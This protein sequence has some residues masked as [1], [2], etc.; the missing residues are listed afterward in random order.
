[1]LTKIVGLLGALA[2]LSPMAMVILLQL[3]L[4]F[5]IPRWLDPILGIALSIPML[6]FCTLA[7]IFLIVWTIRRQEQED[8]PLSR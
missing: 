1:M 3:R 5:L 8:E 4:G 2:F 7:S 6:A